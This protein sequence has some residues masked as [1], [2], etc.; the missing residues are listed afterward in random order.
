MT[1]ISHRHGVIKS[2]PPLFAIM[3]T[4]HS[5][6]NSRGITFRELEESRVPRTYDPNNPVETCYEILYNSDANGDGIVKH[7]EYMSFI[8][9]LSEGEIE[10]TNYIDLPFV[11]KINFVYLSCLCMYSPE[12]QMMGGSECCEGTDAGIYVSGAGPND[13]PTVTEDQYLTTVCSETQ[14]AIDFETD[15]SSS[16]PTDTVTT[17]PTSVPYRSPSTKPTMRVSY[18]VILNVAPLPAK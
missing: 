16:S 15:K 14:G 1:R 12:N 8:G 5:H 4:I 10:V 18:V 3:R 13:T 2:L 6:P 7:D 11:I 9:Q 17:S